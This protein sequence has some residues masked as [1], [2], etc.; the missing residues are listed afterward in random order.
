MYNYYKKKFFIPQ[1]YKKN[2]FGKYKND[3]FIK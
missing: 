2:L 3:K 1:I